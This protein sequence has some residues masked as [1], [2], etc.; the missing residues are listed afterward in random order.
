[1]ETEQAWGA[2]L[3]AHAGDSEDFD[4]QTFQ[5]AVIL[6]H[7]QSCG[8]ALSPRSTSFITHL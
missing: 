3:A 8:R 1:M 5:G 2:S 6:S 4:V 7:T